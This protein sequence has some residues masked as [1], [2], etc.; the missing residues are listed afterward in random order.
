MSDKKVAI[1]LDTLARMADGFRESRSLTDKLT[2][3][4]MI[5]LAAEPP[6]ETQEKTI[7]FTANGT[8]EL[9]PDAGYA[10]SKVT[11]NVNVPS[12][13]KLPQV[14]DKTITELTAEDLEG[15]TT[16]GDYAFYDCDNLT[17]VSLPTSLTSIGRN[18]F[19]SCNNLRSITLPSNVVYIEVY[20]FRNCGALESVTFN[21]GLNAI[22]TEAFNECE[23]LK[24]VVIPDS[25]TIIADRAFY[26][27][28]A[29][30]NMT[31]GRGITRIGS[32]AITSSGMT[33][34]TITFLGTT[35]PTIQ[36][37]SFNHILKM[38][39][40]AGTRDTY[41]NATNWAK[42]ADIIEEATE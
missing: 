40:P 26:Y 3:E 22:Y 10:L 29:L 2:T 12:L 42:Y 37:N 38:I 20:A 17:T 8:Y 32:N 27:T 1:K 23:A 21:E 34:K 24:D 18:S 25:V 4:E 31:I 16:T 36:S 9:Y 7:D 14:V 15:A 41:I 39:V 28:P 33:N 6:I 30:T 11:A 13:N 5:T 19:Q 35:P